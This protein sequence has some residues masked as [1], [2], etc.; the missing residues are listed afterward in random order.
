MLFHVVVVLS[1]SLVD[2]TP[3]MN[4]HHSRIHSALGGHFRLF[5][6]VAIVNSA[7]VCSLLYAFWKKKCIFPLGIYLGVELLDMCMSGFC[8]YCQTVFQ[9]DGTTSHSHLQ[10]FPTLGKTSYLFIF[11][12]LVGV[13]Q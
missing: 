10:L 9:S 8:K 3:F 11:A 4:Y 5:L 13:Q 2:N 1:T 12:I 6:V 7:T